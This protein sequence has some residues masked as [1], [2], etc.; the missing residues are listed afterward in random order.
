MQLGTN[1]ISK[2]FQYKN[3]LSLPNYCRLCLNSTSIQVEH[4][5]STEV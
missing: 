4:K 5:C 2:L 1:E 3:S